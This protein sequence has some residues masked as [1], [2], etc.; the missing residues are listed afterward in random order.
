MLN[1]LLGLGASYAASKLM[2]TLKNQK[3][4]VLH[5]APGR[6]RLQCDRWKNS[7]T[8]GY[9]QSA[10]NGLSIVERA[11]TSP[12]TGSL[13]II[14][15]VQSLTAKQFDEIVRHA[16]KISEMALPQV[17]SDTMKWLETGQVALDKAIK[18]QSG[19]RT[20]LDS[21]LAVTLLATGTSVFGTNP[22]RAVSLILGA[23]N[24]I[25]RNRKDG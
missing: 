25:I 11:E 5:A 23:Y 9:L 4:N 1:T 2:G 14:F 6:V 24:I 7:E 15:K 17:K 18:V 3:V 10:F 8:A 13:L 21:L 22:S 20:D 12:I 16:I 19:G